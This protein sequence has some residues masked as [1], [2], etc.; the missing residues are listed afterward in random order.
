[1]SS[2]NKQRVLIVDDTPTQ[3]KIIIELL[4]QDHHV[5]FAK[6]GATGLDLARSKAPDLILLD[7]MMPDMDGYEVVRRLKADPA[8]AG[9][10]V[11]FLTARTKAEDETHGLQ[12]GAV[13]YI[14]KPVVPAV[15][16]ARVETHLR[17]KQKADLL[18]RLACLDGLTDLPNRRRLDEYLEQEWRRTVRSGRPL[19]V[20]MVDV[21]HFKAFND[22]YGHGAGDACLRQ[23]AAALRGVLRRPADLAARYGGEEFC[24]VLPEIDLDG[25]TAVA[26]AARAAVEGL[27]IP[28]AH[29]GCADRVTIS[30]GGAA[31]VPTRE[32]GVAVLREA[33][34]AML[35]AAKNEGR[36]RVKLRL[37][38]VGAGQGGTHG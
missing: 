9:I 30:L 3:L 36:N 5:I 15:L 11:I 23:V 24:L 28:H 35:Y 22:A 14:A 1:V 27:G 29:S 37:L 13:D 7:I 33:A 18:E 32:G 12:L 31:A 17:L 20:L 6:D 10:P 8:T 34:D 21:D 2:P 4:R 16:K 19:A 26:E 38:K 25:A